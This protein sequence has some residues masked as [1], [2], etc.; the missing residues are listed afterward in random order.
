MMSRVVLL[1]MAGMIVLLA[2][3]DDSITYPRQA[4]CDYS[5]SPT[6]CESKYQPVC[7]TDGNSY[8]NEC[9]LCNEN[10]ER[11]DNIVDIQ[12]EDRC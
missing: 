3:A 6:D 12:K 8:S 10:R 4:N 11:P 1:I 7:G 2:K 5:S 9:F